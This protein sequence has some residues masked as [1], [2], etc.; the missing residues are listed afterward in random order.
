MCFATGNPQA[1][2]NKATICSACH[3]ENGQSTQPLWPN[4]AGQHARYLVQQLHYFQTG[5]ERQSPVMSPLV[6]SLNTQDIEDIAA[7]YAQKPLAPAKTASS[8]SSHGEQLYRAG[9]ISLHIPACITCHGP[10]GRGA[11]QAGFPMISHQQPEYLIQQLQA[12]KTKKRRTDPLEIMR[13]ICAQL[14]E[15]DMQELANYIAGL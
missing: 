11:E 5:T 12:F 7:F 14:T 9:D 15:K 8:P 2:Q 10:D 6:A 13:S 4:I 3:G 1:G